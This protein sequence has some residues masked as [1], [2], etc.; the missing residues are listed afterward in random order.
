MVSPQ[1]NFFS[2]E[3]SIQMLTTPAGLV[4]LPRLLAIFQSAELWDILPTNPAGFGDLS[5]LTGGPSREG[6]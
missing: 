6:R 3:Q 4:F 2:P 5:E 1:R